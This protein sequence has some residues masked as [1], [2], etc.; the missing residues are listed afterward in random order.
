MKRREFLKYACEAGFMVALA[1]AGIAWSSDGQYVRPPGSVAEDAFFKKCV[2]CGICVQVCPTHGLDFVGLTK[3]LKNIGTPKLNVKEGGCIAWKEPCLKCVDACP[4][5]VLIKPKELK[6]VR[7][8]SAFIRE[9]ECINCLMCFP[10][11]PVEGAV[12]FPN[13]KGEPFLK[14]IA[15]PSTLSHKDSPLKS[16]IDNGKCI[17]CGLCAYICPVLCIDITPEN[18]VRMPV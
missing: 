6:H 8:G 18:E 14:T 4:T 3:D 1:G 9:K 2:K 13:P 11:C 17:G 7:M 10:E 15:I 12:V 16:Y 5:D